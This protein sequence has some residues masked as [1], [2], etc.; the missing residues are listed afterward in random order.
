M[1]GGVATQP[2]ETPTLDPPLGGCYSGLVEIMY[3]Q[4]NYWFVAV[5]CDLLLCTAF[6][7]CTH[8]PTFNHNHGG[9]IKTSCVVVYFCSPG[10]DVV[11]AFMVTISFHS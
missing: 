8:S 10:T 11:W 7:L 2:P 6:P 3:V 1:F 9:I 5:H 4:H